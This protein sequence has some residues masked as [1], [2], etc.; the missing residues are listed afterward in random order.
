MSD[1]FEH[2]QEH[3]E[4]AADEHG[5]STSHTRAAIIIGIMAAVLA[6]TEFVAK[7]AQ[8]DYLTNHIA[9]SD[10]WAQYQA[11]SV[12][13]TILTA[14]ADLLESMPAG[15][16]PLVK[17]RIA[18]AR[19]NAERMRSEPG[20]DGMEQLSEK[21]HDQ[22]HERDHAMH[23]NHILEIASGGLQIAI[24]LASISVVINLPAFMLVSV[25]VGGASAIYALLGGFS[26]L[27]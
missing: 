4:H 7:D 9:A 16:D 10:T 18:D 22:E 20:A 8:T 21:A 11:K 3:L 5:G 2:A 25:L 23:R 13:R 19:A 14:Q 12:R 24:V 1:E 6:I 15:S 17:K 26:L 27:H